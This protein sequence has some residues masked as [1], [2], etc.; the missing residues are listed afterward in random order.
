MQPFADDGNKRT[1][2]VL[3]NVFLIR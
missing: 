1:S 2:R 3:S